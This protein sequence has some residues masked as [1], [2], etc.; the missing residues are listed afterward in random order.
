MEILVALAVTSLLAASVVGVFV[1]ILNVSEDS[2]ARLRALANARA[3]AETLSR[4]I[5]SIVTAPGPVLVRGTNDPLDHGNAID[6]DSDG[7]TDEEQP[8][9]DDEDGDWADRH[10][11]AGSFSERPN[12]VGTPDLGDVGVDEDCLFQNDSLAFRI[13][14]PDTGGGGPS[15]ETILYE[16]REF[17]GVPHVLVRTTTQTL[18]GGGVESA[19]A[20]LA[21]DVLSF[22]CLYWNPNAAPAEQNWETE[23]DSA[24][25]P[26]PMSLFRAPAAVVFELVVYAGRAPIEDYE[27]GRPAQ[28]VTL[29]SAVNVESVIQSAAFP[30]DP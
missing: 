14:L 23:W 15:Y 4:E 5:K 12:R 29:R 30:R 9:G 2:Q 7:R 10:A 3:A 11:Q 21:Y 27:E 18:T 22:N 26:G 1:T 17:E 19:S 25:P 24:A 16:V 28:T 8:N 20:P 13:A 6:D